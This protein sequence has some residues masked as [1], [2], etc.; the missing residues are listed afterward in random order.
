MTRALPA[1]W[2]TGIALLCASVLIVCVGGAPLEVYRL[3][4]DGTWGN[5]YGLGQVVFKT[6]PLVFTGLSVAMALRAGLFNIGAEGQLTVGAFCTAMVATWNGPRSA[7]LAVP[8]ALGAGFV[9]GALVG[10]IPGVLKATRGAHEVI[11]TIM[12]NFIVRAGMVGV[13]AHV[14]L[15]ESVHTAPIAPQYQLPRLSAQVSA[16]AGSAANASLFVAVATALGCWWLLRRTRTGFELRAVGE[17]PAAAETAGIPVGRRIVLAM[18][19]AGG[20]AGLTG[21]S[22]VLGYKHYYEDGF[23][24]GIGYM[25]IAVAVLGRAEPLGVLAAALLF[26]T[27]SQGALAVNAIVPKELVDVLMAVIIFA[28]VAAAPEV[29]RLV[30]A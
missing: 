23:S 13:G 25:G 28:V 3:L 8:L 24:G 30:K 5:A 6:T 21:S 27:L 9:G 12:L 19:L 7:W 18:A 11:N 4:V 15:R 1:V 22:F 17:S 20:I 26:G 2:A 14:F 29:K 16:L 10:A